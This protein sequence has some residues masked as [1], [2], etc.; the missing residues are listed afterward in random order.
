MLQLNYQQ[1][2]W[3]QYKC[4]IVKEELRAGYVHRIEYYA[5]AENVSG[6]FYPAQEKVYNMLLLK[7]VTI[8]H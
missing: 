8:Y 2:S 6:H 1:K 5:A 4:P 7:M 3:E